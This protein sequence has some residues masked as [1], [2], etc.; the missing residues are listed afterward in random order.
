MEL[1]QKHIDRYLAALEASEYV[2]QLVHAPGLLRPYRGTVTAEAFGMAERLKWLRAKNMEGYQIYA[3]PVGWRYVLLDD[4]TPEALP[5]A[6][7]LRPCI[8]ME[9]S[10]KNYQAWLRLEEEPG[11]RAE[12]LAICRE[13]AGM[14]GAD[15]GSAEPDHVGR[16]PGFTNR[17]E[18]YRM[19]KGF[20]FVRLWQA[21]PCL[22]PFQPKGTFE[23]A[24]SAPV[25]G[26]P[27]NNGVL[28]G[29]GQDRSRADFNLACMLVRQGKSDAHI[30]ERLEATS[31]KAQGRRDDYIGRTIY[32]ARRAVGGR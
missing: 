26:Y 27:S 8:V 2:L 6:L 17:K 24:Q 1:L 4:I 21:Q 7:Q 10:P 30:R 31:E 19:A 5:H 11:S 13:L 23:P 32:N 3:R 28:N 15:R 22:T 12:A 29:A 9:T 20:P 16:L 25:H 18:K 14:L